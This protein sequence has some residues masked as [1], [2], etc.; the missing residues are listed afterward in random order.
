MRWIGVFSGLLSLAPLPVA[1]QPASY[2]VELGSWHVMS[3]LQN[4]QAFNRDPAEYNV[5]PYNALNLRQAAGAKGAALYL[6]FWPG[7]FSP[8]QEVSLT[9]QYF[10]D[11]GR[12][13]DEVL[14]GRAQNDFLVEVDRLFDGKA[15]QML[16][17]KRFIVITPE[18]GVGALGFDT[19]AMTE[20]G[21]HLE[22][23][24]ARLKA[25]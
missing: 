16:A 3:G 6:S 24:A 9:F 12:A 22:S 20:I 23:C 19:Q 18:N 14:K 5:A 17:D 8:A 11:A 15:L 10:G 7:A 25:K 13:D 21:S 1:A 4:C 2:Y